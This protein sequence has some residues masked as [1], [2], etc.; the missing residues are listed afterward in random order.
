MQQ[1]RLA[2][3]VFEAPLKEIGDYVAAIRERRPFGLHVS[4]PA[5]RWTEA[6]APDLPAK[7]LDREG[8]DTG[9]DVMEIL[10]H[11]V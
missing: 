11:G 10:R 5:E 1:E 2:G 3:V 4:R 6:V 9:A 7:W 8:Q